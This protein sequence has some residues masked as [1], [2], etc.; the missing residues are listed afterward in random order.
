MNKQLSP[1]LQRYFR[2]ITEIICNQVRKYISIFKQINRSYGPHLKCALIYLLLQTPVAVILYAAT[3]EPW[4]RIQVIKF[5][6][7]M[8]AVILFAPRI[9]KIALIRNKLYWMDAL[10]TK[11]LLALEQ[12]DLTTLHK[13][14]QPNNIAH[15]RPYFVRISILCLITAI[16]G[17]FLKERSS[18]NVITLSLSLYLLVQLF[19]MATAIHVKGK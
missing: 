8:T 3:F 19:L 9:S 17:Q 2:I 11:Q 15:I 7:A 14:G 10:T 6:L 18:I 5:T 16:F 12:L 1:F 4:I 13:E